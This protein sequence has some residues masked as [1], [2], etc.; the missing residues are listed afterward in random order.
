MSTLLDAAE[1]QKPTYK[2]ERELTVRGL[3]EESRWWGGITCRRQDK[4]DDHFPAIA[5]DSWFFSLN[6]HTRLK[7]RRCLPSKS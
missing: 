3:Q 1:T 7:G 6:T 5:D 4:G 2:L